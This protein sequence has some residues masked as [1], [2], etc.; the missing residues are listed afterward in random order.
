[1]K[2]STGHVVRKAL[3]VAGLT[4]GFAVLLSSLI[5][6]LATNTFAA[7]T[8]KFG[9]G[10]IAGKPTGITGKYMIDNDSAIDA[11]IGWETSGDNEFHVYGDYL[12]HLYDLIKVKKGKLPLYFGG[13]IR[14]VN[15]E[16]RDN[17]FG[18]RIPVG[19]EYLFGNLPLGAFL[20]LAPVLD[21]TPDT[22][23]DLEGGIGIRYFF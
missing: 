21:L 12:Y 13:G 2:T 8:G 15:R 17:K 1:M 4:V 11:G 10:V 14:F 20:E 3:T 5:V 6:F 9:I 16:N 23:F 7:E 19:I 22:E 18:I